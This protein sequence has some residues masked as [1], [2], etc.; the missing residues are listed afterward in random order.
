MRRPLLITAAAACGLFLSPPLVANAAVATPAPPGHASGVAAQVGSLLDI[1][2]TDATADS[3]APTAQAS[4]VRIQGQPLMNLGGTQKGDGES[5]GA[6]ADTGSSLP[7][8]VEVAPW[9]ATARGSHGPNRQAMG[10]AAVARVGLPK[11]V[12]AAVLNSRSEAS[13]TDEHSTGT[14]ISD[15]LDLNLLDAAR[16]V[17]LHSEVSS[18]GRGHSYLVG[19]NDTRLGTDDQLGHSPLCALNAPSVLALSCLT[20][21]GGNAAPGAGGV[22]S[23]AAEVARVT[24]APAALSLLNPL[25][26]IS[27]AASS[28]SG[29]VAVPAAPLPVVAAAETSRSANPPAAATVSRTSQGTGQLPRTGTAL[30]P[31][32]ATAIAALLGGLA[33]RRMRPRRLALA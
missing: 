27:T 33:L 3:G 29:T 15:G 14:A 30:V 24:P 16:L 31:T 8:R 21:S 20:A 5:G 18:D 7:A 9:H 2:K 32:V 10:S 19:I 28:G 25:S 13:Y 12:S 23:A 4:V 26:A 22:A 1:S 6:L 11:V 17:L